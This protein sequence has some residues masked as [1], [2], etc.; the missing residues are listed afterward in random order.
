MLP[1]ACWLNRQEE[2]KEGRKGCD[3]VGE[4]RQISCSP[5][6]LRCL[7]FAEAAADLYQNDRIGSECSS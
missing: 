4:A 7:Q 1:F 3:E 6:L 5:P 2:K